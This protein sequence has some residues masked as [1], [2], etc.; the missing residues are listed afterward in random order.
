MAPGLLSVNDLVNIYHY[1]DLNKDTQIYGLIGDPVAQSVGHLYHNAEFVKA[2]Q[3]AVYVKFWVKPEELPE[4]FQA[5]QDLPLQGL[6]VTMPHK[7]AVLNFCTALTHSVQVIGA[8]NTLIKQPDGF[9]AA[10][11]DGD[12]VVQVLGKVKNK[13]IILLGAGGAASSIIYSLINAGAKVSVYNRTLDKLEAL[14]EKY[15]I[16]TFLLE[17]A[18][19]ADYDILINTIPA[20]FYQNNLKWIKHKIIMDINYQA[21]PTLLIQDA[22]K[23]D[24]ICI[25]GYAMFYE[26]ALRQQQLWQGPF[27]F[28]LYSNSRSK[29]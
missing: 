9:L 19:K 16:E 20:K 12:A 1:F 17:D 8:A 26:Q 5:I 3:N 29:K 21:T 6:S 13:K 23:Q 11:T 22:M 14:R 24:C 18:D 2:K 27:I 28:T 7:Q 4:F 15:P 25:D 10:N